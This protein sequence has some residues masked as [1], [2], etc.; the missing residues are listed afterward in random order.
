VAEVRSLGQDAP[1][2]A[3]VDGGRKAASDLGKD[4]RHVDRA[5]ARRAASDVNAERSE[6]RAVDADQ[7][8]KNG[9]RCP[10]A[11]R[12]SPRCALHMWL[13]ARAR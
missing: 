4:G 1:R 3:A 8:A 12:H 10:T 7:A 2:L 11:A 5:P 9:R 13:S 6:R